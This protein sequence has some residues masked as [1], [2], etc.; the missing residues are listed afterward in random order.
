[1][2]AQGPASDT[3]EELFDEVQDFEAGCSVD[4]LGLVCVKPPQRPPDAL[5]VKQVA[6][7]TWAGDAGIEVGSTVLEVNGTNAAGLGASEIK[8]AMAQ[9]PLH[10]RLAKPKAPEWRRVSHF[11]KDAVRLTLR[12]S[13]LQTALQQEHS[14][15]LQ[16]E[17]GQINGV[18][19]MKEDEEDSLEW[20]AASRTRLQDELFK[21]QSKLQR[22]T[23]ETETALKTAEDHFRQR[24]ASA[25][26][27]FEKER[28]ELQAK[29]HEV[30]EQCKELQAHAVQGGKQQEDL[31][32]ADSEATGLRKEVEL[33]AQRIIDIEADALRNAESCKSLQE[34]LLQAESK[35]RFSSWASLASG[36]QAIDGKD[37]PACLSQTT[38]GFHEF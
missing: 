33:S 16:L 10:L 30:Q 7:D 25:L 20:W 35:L 3:V 6:P 18:A 8:K 34:A 32:D 31:R 2:S 15:L 1:M 4:R 23:L 22:A 12:V 13:K 28:A 26:E 24:E 14:R 19:A 5:V 21:A 36:G 37:N 11:Q 9:R 38:S 17:E 29:L 27:T